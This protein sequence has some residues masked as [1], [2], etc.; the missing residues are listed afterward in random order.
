M[1]SVPFR[2]RNT[3]SSSS[4]AIFMLLGLWPWLLQA[5]MACS[6]AVLPWVPL[7]YCLLFTTLFAIYMNFEDLS[8][9]KTGQVLVSWVVE[10]S[11]LPHC[12]TYHRSS[13]EHQSAFALWS[14]YS[15]RRVKQFAWRVGGHE[16]LPNLQ[17]LWETAMT[18]HETQ[19]SWSKWAGSLV[20]TRVCYGIIR[21][22]AILLVY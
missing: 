4:P 9:L 7:F 3:S 5:A 11:D 17:L 14:L 8:I 15:P 13:R 21:R 12:D 18:V 10:A 16:H 6:L 19:Q 1:I 22:T 2:H 20:P